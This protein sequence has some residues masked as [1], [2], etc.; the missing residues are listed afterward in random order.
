MLH[1]P[2][3]KNTDENYSGAVKEIYED[4]NELNEKTFNAIGR[5]NE[6]QFFLFLANYIYY[7][8]FTDIDITTLKHFFYFKFKY[9]IENNFS[10]PFQDNTE[11]NEEAKYRILPEESLSFNCEKKLAELVTFYL[12]I[13]EYPKETQSH[14]LLVLSDKMY[15]HILYPLN[16]FKNALID[17]VDNVNIE[18][19]NCDIKKISFLLEING[20][21]KEYENYLD[22]LQSQIYERIALLTKSKNGTR[23]ENY[24][25]NIDSNLL[26]KLYYG[27]EKF[28]FIDQTKTTLDQFIEVFELDWKAHNSIIYLEMDHIQTRYFFDCMDQYLKTK[29]YS[30]FI[31]RA[32]NIENKNGKI[33]ANNIYTSV[34]KS[35]LDPK[36]HSLIKSIFEELQKG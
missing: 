3:F 25:I 31:E 4:L 29:I 36:K 22:K 6:H 23:N 13:K 7:F 17:Y 1:Y 28:M 2:Y 12:D 19:N 15:E 26:K 20:A 33:K 11:D 30:T 16:I 35:N 21:L 32:G 5:L 27:L 9:K 10:L 8:R 18:D 34:S 24:S 14:M